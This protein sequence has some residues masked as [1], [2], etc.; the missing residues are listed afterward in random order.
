MTNPKSQQ[1]CATA[2]FFKPQTQQSS[3][4][5][6]LVSSLSLSQWRCI[7]FRLSLIFNAQSTAVQKMTTTSPQIILP[8][9]NPTTTALAPTPIGTVTPRWITIMKFTRVLPSQHHQILNNSVKAAR[10]ISAMSSR[11]PTFRPKHTDRQ[12]PI[13]DSLSIRHLHRHWL[14]FI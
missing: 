8:S 14:A 11:T 5:W 10:S 2:E 3:K 9:L 7:N 12:F 4:H 6:R 13:I 1:F